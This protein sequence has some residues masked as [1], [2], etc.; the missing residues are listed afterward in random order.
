MATPF[1]DKLPPEIRKEIYECLLDFHVPL[2]HI[3]QLQPFVKKLT[4][5]DGELPS[6]YEDPENHACCR[7]GMDDV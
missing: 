7:A 3:S 6:A 2:R 4:G 5:V 1:L